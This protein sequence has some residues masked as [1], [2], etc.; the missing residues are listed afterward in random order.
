MIDL[1]QLIRGLAARPEPFASG[2]AELWTDPLVAPQ[3]LAAHLDANIDAASRKPETI[4]RE[5]DWLVDELKLAAGA[6]VLDL[7]CGPGLYCEALA[8]RG[9]IVTGVDSSSHSIEYARRHAAEAGLDIR[10]VETD[11]R[12]FDE[13]GAY[14]AAIL[15]YLDFGVLADRDRR[16]VLARV[17]HALRPRARFAFDVVSTAAARPEGTSWSTSAGA[18][19]WRPWPHL[20]LERRLY[21]PEEKVS[22][23]EHAV[24]DERG[25]ATIYRIWEQHF[26]RET[27]EALLAAAE[28]EIEELAADL[29]GARWTPESETL[30]VIA[31]RT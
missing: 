1:E 4:A 27:L 30:A 16:L 17:R 18:G 24:I 21:F 15:V 9:L 8:A 19:F 23:R 3:L 26:S 6:R 13:E 28:F 10:Y 11:Y 31:R 20:V 22:G 5:V 7:G 12:C 2:D 29:T 25:A 14:D